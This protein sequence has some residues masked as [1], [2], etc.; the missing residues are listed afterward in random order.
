MPQSQQQQQKQQYQQHQ[1]QQQNQYKHLSSSALL[2]SNP[3]H[4]QKIYKLKV[5]F[6][7]TILPNN[8][9]ILTLVSIIFYPIFKIFDIRI[10]PFWVERYFILVGDYL[11]K[12]KPNSKNQM[13]IAN[14]HSHNTNMK[15]KGSPIPIQNITITPLQRLSHGII[16]R[17]TT[18]TT[19][20]NTNTN[21]M[22]TDN[23]PTHPRCN[24]YFSITQRISKTTYYATETPSDAH[25]WIN[26]LHSAKQ[27]CIMN[28]LG[29]N[30][31]NGNS[32]P[33]DVKVEYMNVL[34]KQ[35]VDRKERIRDLIRKKELEDVEF[36]CLN[37]AG[38]GGGI[39]GHPRGVFG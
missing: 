39:G 37:G 14:S 10:H 2:K 34:G 21:T 33:K 28:Q 20:T 30:G 22:L 6:I 19:N 13:T 26:I 18:T 5:P 4:H 38:V 23:V 16:S 31:H 8:A 1:Q 29:H 25:T 32:K 9:I 15:L 17:S 11:Y 12:Y 24:G 27:E 35:M 7:S 36:I 3:T